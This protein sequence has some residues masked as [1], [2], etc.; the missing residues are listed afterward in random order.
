V[1]S[2][3]L[4]VENDILRLDWVNDINKAISDIN[5][6]HPSDSKHF[7]EYVGKREGEKRESKDGRLDSAPS[8]SRAL[9]DVA[10]FRVSKEGELVKQGIK[11]K[12]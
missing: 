3:K 1:V 12:V 2:H 8:T 11:R 5:A 9:V 7:S 10:A 4:A 6:R